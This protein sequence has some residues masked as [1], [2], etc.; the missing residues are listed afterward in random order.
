MKKI[1]KF[2]A[3]IGL[4]ISLEGAPVTVTTGF[5]TGQQFLEWE[6]SL[7]EFYAIGAINGI[8]LAPLAMGQ[9]DIKQLDW[10]IKFTKGMTNKQAAAIIRKYLNDHP[11]LWNQTL[12]IVTYNA[13]RTA[14]N[15]VYGEK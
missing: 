1:I 14:Y 8:L 3:M 12:N 7:Q 2:V 5:G 15:K 4:C 9:S 11:E 10:F 6:S 13:F